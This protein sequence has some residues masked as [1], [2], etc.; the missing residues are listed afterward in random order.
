MKNHPSEDKI[1]SFLHGELSQLENMK[2]EQHIDHC[3]KCQQVLEDMIEAQATILPNLLDTELRLK[4]NQQDAILELAKQT[5]LKPA[6]KKANFHIFYKVAAIF[7]ALFVTV[8]SLQSPEDIVNKVVASNNQFNITT[9]LDESGVDNRYIISISSNKP[10]PQNYQPQS[11]T[12]VLDTSHTKINPN[13]FKL[14]ENHIAGI[15]DRVTENDKLTVII[16]GARRGLLEAQLADLGKTEAVDTILEVRLSARPELIDTVDYGYRYAESTYVD[17]AKNSV[18]LL[19]ST[20]EITPTIKKGLPQR[21]DKPI[22]F[23]I[24]ELNKSGKL[25]D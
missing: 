1:S 17:Q 18:I 20:G 19:T 8:Y 10:A 22:N 7:I 15:M 14:L 6:Q 24:V 2:L 11:V 23:S 5:T 3:E 21:S 12:V 9:K 16:N 4:P 25:T 13:E